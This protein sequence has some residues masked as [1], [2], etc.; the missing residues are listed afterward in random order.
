M[1]FPLSFPNLAPSPAP[2]PPHQPPDFT[3]HSASCNSYAEPRHSDPQ[4]TH[5]PLSNLCTIFFQT[6]ISPSGLDSQLGLP[7]WFLTPALKTSTFQSV[8]WF[9]LMH[10]KPQRIFYV[11]IRNRFFFSFFFCGVHLEDFEPKRVHRQIKQGKWVR[12]LFR[13]IF[14]SHRTISNC[15]KVLTRR[16]SKNPACKDWLCNLVKLFCCRQSLNVFMSTNLMK[17]GE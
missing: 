8:A 16:E 7:L 3:S 2:E 6:S 1:F 4:I 11:T 9:P 5:P 15:I 13:V 12:V 14:W 10:F 17:T